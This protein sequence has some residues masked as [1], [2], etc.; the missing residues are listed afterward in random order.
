MKPLNRYLAFAFA[1]VA[2]MSSCSNDD[3]GINNSSGFEVIEI[4]TVSEINLNETDMTI[5]N[6]ISQFG[7][8]LFGRIIS[9]NN[10]LRNPNI[11]VSPLSMAISLGLAA[12]SHDDNFKNIVIK[13]MGCKDIPELNVYFNKMLRYLPH[14][15]NGCETSFAN[16]VWHISS[17]SPSSYITDISKNVY[18]APINSFKEDERFEVVNRIN[19]W[20]NLSTKGMIPR[21]M[22]D[23]DGVNLF[24]ITLNAMYFS[25]KWETT[26][27]KSKT[28]KQVFY[29]VNGNVTVD[30][31]S[32]EFSKLSYL[33]SDKAI[34]AYLP[35]VGDYYMALVLPAENV[36]IEDVADA[37]TLRM[38]ES[39]EII[40]GWE[41]RDASYLYLP[42]FK[43]SYFNWL[44]EYMEEMGFPCVGYVPEFDLGAPHITYLQKTV[45]EVDEEGTKAA[46]ASGVK[47][48]GEPTDLTFD[49]PFLY[50]IVNKTTGLSLITGYVG[51]PTVSE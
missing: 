40:E 27:D 50:S 7:L 13:T 28:S 15:D 25:D 33:K 46:A 30:M 3:D 44:N 1:I 49:R 19:Q 17:C 41:S 10:Y 23:N 31:M 20:C 43:V 48:D 16:S 38:P 32:G 37:L 9:S 45:V 21:I 39:E 18:Y 2:T 14:K 11:S 36:S 8:E 4:P 24:M 22:R 12:N 42:K 6:H 35:Y 5:S 26:F 34:V 51:D 47:V 29:G